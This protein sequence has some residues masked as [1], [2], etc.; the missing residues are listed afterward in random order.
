MATRAVAHGIFSNGSIWSNI[1]RSNLDALN[2]KNHAASIWAHDAFQNN[3]AE[4]GTEVTIMRDMYGVDKIHLVG[5]LKVDW[6]RA[7]MLAEMMMWERLT[8]LASPNGGSP[9]AD[10]AQGIVAGG[11]LWYSDGAA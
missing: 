1:W 6:I 5:H 9:L 3:S 7:I 2:I 4:I 8:Q 11:C 10:Y